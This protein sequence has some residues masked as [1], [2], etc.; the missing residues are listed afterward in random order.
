MSICLTL[1]IVGCSLIREWIAPDYRPVVLLDRPV[2]HDIVVVDD[3]NLKCM[4]SSNYALF[5]DDVARLLAWG[6]AYEDQVKAA[7]EYYQRSD[8]G[9]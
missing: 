7:L 6:A 2:L 1:A 5:I 3:G 9:R 4:T 8:G